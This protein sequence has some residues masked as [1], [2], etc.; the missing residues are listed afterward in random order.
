MIKLLL[1]T[2][3]FEHIFRS[4]TKCL[5]CVLHTFS[6][7]LIIQ[8]YMYIYSFE[9]LIYKV[10]Y[11]FSLIHIAVF[12]TLVKYWINFKF[13]YISHYKRLAKVHFFDFEWNWIELIAI[14]FIDEHIYWLII[15]FLTRPDAP[16]D[17]WSLGSCTPPSCNK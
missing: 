8:I 2:N 13:E 11:Q 16:E 17:Q 12:C 4:F 7:F 14:W 9:I 6:R 15:G 10:K 3:C 1:C 5:K